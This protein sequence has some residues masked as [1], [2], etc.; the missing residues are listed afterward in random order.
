M[1]GFKDRPYFQAEAGSQE[2]PKVEF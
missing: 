1:L 2:A